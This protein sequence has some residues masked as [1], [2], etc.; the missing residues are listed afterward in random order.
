MQLN[1]KQTYILHQTQKLSKEF[2]SHWLLLYNFSNKDNFV[3][4]I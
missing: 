1:I 3:V 4:Y 2:C